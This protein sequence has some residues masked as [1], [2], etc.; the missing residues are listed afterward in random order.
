LPEIRR[1]AGAIGKNLPKHGQILLGTRLAMGRGVVRLAVLVIVSLL[2]PPLLPLCIEGAP[3]AH[4]CC[5]KAAP[6]A[7]KLQ[8]CCTTSEQPRVPARATMT[9]PIART[10]ASVAPV[11]DRPVVTRVADVLAALETP[12]LTY[13]RHIALLI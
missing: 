10:T 5:R 8:L 9:A 12:S 6:A 3:A 2:A 4:D 7:S 1:L 13:L 11:I